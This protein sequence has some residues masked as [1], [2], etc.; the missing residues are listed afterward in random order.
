MKDT[1]FKH[2][3]RQ[4]YSGRYAAGL[5]PPSTSLSSHEDDIEQ[6]A[7]NGENDSHTGQSRHYC[8][9]NAVYSSE[10]QF[11]DAAWEWK[12][13]KSYHNASYDMINHWPNQNILTA[14]ESLLALPLH[15]G[16]DSSGDVDLS[17]LHI[18]QH[19]IQCPPLVE[20]HTSALYLSVSFW[21]ESY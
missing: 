9:Q 21:G 18:G 17:H 13:I 20:K 15:V 10:L 2:C 4:A 1:M 14:K 6:K 16:D 19:P 7:H 8:K 12:A 3:T 5:D 11:G